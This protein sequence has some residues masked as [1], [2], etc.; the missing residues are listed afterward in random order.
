MK[1]TIVPGTIPTGELH[2]YLLGSVAPRPIAFVSTI[3][4]EGKPNLAPYSFFN[5]FS[6]N[7]PILVFSS[8]RRVEGNTTKDTLHNI[9]ETKECVVN[10]VNYEIVRQMMVCSV[11][12][13]KEVNEFE[14]AGLTPEKAS[15][16]KSPL[17]LES[18]VNMECKVDQIITLG[19]QGGAGHLIVCHVVCI[20]I[21]ESVLDQHQKIDPH[22][23]DLMGRM[24]RA[25][26]VRASGEAI[27][28]LPQSQQ[29][30]VVGYKNLPD[31]VS[32]SKILTANLIGFL[33]GLKHWPD[34]RESVAE[35]N[36]RLDWKEAMNS[37]KR[38][39]ELHHLAMHHFNHGNSDLAA[40]I[41]AS[42]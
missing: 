28:T 33:C 37:P 31:H 18:P 22:K 11:D 34:Q 7:P 26:Y 27:L 15:F 30:P 13:P 36:E 38:L 6:S 14:E 17:V 12:F 4:K 10:V 35:L 3:D 8:N 16:I 39:D 25:F 24:G 19:D 29:L 20:H 32:Q 21:S 9:M 1:K 40:K 2:Q 42:I 41:L 5:A 23:I